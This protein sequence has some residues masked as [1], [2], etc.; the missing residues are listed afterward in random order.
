MYNHV[1]KK[2]LVGG[3]EEIRMNGV[4]NIHQGLVKLCYFIKFV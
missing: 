1:F 4:S 2:I 3:T